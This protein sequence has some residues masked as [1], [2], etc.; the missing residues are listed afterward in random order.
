[1]MLAPLRVKLAQSYADR[2]RGVGLCVAWREF[3]AVCMPRCRAVHTL[4]LARPIDVVFV[5]VDTTIVEV[6]HRVRPWRI[7]V[8]RAPNAVDAWEFPAGSC[9]A[10]GVV[11]GLSIDAMLCRMV[12]S[13]DP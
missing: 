10:C 2:L 6:R 4:A 11:A 9:E 3:D 8:T 7:V 13:S 5:S 1:M 12:R